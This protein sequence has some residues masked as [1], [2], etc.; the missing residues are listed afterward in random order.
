M[1]FSGSSEDV[2]KNKASPKIEKLPADN[3]YKLKAA[4]ESAVPLESA[5]T[6]SDPVRDRSKPSK[7]MLAG[8]EPVKPSKAESVTSG[9]S[10]NI[11]TKITKAKN[12]KEKKQENTGFAEDIV[13][14]DQR[15]NK[16][17]RSSK[18]QKQRSIEQ[19]EALN[20]EN[21][22]TQKAGG[23]RKQVEPNGVLPE[24]EQHN[25]KTKKLKYH[26]R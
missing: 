2:K 12:L 25:I 16:Q 22:N 4:A 3:L 13:S 9:A 5:A 24:M 8:G 20:L 26:K 10:D 7:D 17:P 14:G 15:P 18:T 23:E 11:P 19:D 6:G 21:V 1:T